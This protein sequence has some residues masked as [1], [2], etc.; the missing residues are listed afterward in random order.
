MSGSRFGRLILTQPTGT[1]KTLEKETPTQGR[2]TFHSI[3][4]AGD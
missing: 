3:F 2:R 4:P 1:A